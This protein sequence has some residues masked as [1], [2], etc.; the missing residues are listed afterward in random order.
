MKKEDK[1]ELSRREFLK[2]TVI[3][4]AALGMG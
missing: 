1:K 2:G 4:T 3:G